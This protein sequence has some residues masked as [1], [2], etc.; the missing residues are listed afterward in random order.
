MLGGRGAILV[1][2]PFR[3]LDGTIL[4]CSDGV[5]DGTCDSDLGEYEGRLH[6]SGLCES[7]VEYARSR[8]RDNI[9]VVAATRKE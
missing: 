9:T 6:S 3:L 7:L 5:L 2:Y 4:L 8:S 1:F